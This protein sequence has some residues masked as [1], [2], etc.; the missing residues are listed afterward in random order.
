[1]FQ[2]KVVIKC[3]SSERLLIFLKLSESAVLGVDLFLTSDLERHILF[4]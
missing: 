4:E 1:M 3:T 2:M